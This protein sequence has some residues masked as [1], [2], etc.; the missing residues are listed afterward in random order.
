MSTNES[1]PPDDMGSAVA[2]YGCVPVPLNSGLHYAPANTPREDIPIFALNDIE[3]VLDEAIG[4]LRGTL[5]P[6]RHSALDNL[7]Q[8]AMVIARARLNDEVAAYYASRGMFGV[9]R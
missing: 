9:G 5:H 4:K 6:A 8:E 1:G 2:A 3:A 7:K